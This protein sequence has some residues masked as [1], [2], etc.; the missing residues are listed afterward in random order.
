M[1]GARDVERTRKIILEAART[2]FAAAGYGAT[3]LRAI[4][5]EAGVSP[6][7][8]I[9]HF[10]SKSELFLR[11]GPPHAPLGEGAIARPRLGRALVTRIL[12]RQRAGSAEPWL[13]VLSNAR[14]V[15]ADSRIRE[16]V[17]ERIV[18][19][20]AELVGDD[21]EDALT[22]Q[23]II[24]QLVGLAEGVGTLGLLHDADDERTIDRYARPIQELIDSLPA[25][26]ARPT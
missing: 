22:A 18:R 4:A 13:S 19:D 3:T 17:R 1:S 9:K 21:T 15:P 6:A 20:V 11:V 2:Q 16:Q 10:E 24:C 5:A 26:E 25:R 8:I 23:L 12:R 7:L 14:D